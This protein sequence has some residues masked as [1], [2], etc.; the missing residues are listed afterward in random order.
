MAEIDIVL[1]AT[2][3][4]FAK[5]TG[6]DDLINESCDDHFNLFEFLSLMSHLTTEDFVYK[7]I[8]FLYFLSGSECE[9]CSSRFFCRLCCCLLSL[10]NERFDSRD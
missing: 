6:V 2:T 8:L 5:L 4:L 7:Y 1:Q 9:I 3:I 10:Q